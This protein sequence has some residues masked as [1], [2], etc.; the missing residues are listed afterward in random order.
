MGFETNKRFRPKYG[1]EPVEAMVDGKRIKF[2]S[3]FEYRWAQYLDFLKN[4]GE[5]KGWWYEFCT[6]RYRDRLKPPYEWTPD[7][8]VRTVKNELEHYECKGM[9]QRYDLKKLKLL[10]EERPL[11]KVIYVFWSKPKI[12]VQKKEQLERWCERVIWDARKMLKNVPIDM[13]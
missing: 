11:V 1:N 7:F 5:I 13:A 2:K 12:S 4:A 9:L 8:V 10:N 6:F 3:K